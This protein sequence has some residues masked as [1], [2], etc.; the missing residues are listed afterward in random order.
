MIYNLAATERLQEINDISARLLLI[1]LLLAKAWQIPYKH[2][3][4]PIIPVKYG[5]H[6]LVINKH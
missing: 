1:R 2:G 4:S 5:T 3:I 6:F